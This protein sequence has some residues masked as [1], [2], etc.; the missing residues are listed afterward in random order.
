MWFKDFS[1]TQILGKINLDDFEATKS[2]ILTIFKTEFLV[3]GEFQPT[4]IA[5]FH[6]N[7]NSEPPKMQ[8]WRFWSF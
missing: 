1:A 5:K 7:Q 3:L 8:K 6:H 2:A 4:K